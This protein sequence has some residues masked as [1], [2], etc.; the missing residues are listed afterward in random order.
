MNLDIL[1]FVLYASAVFV[2]LGITLVFS[3]FVGSKSRHGRAQDIPYESGIVPVG[4]AENMRLSVEFFLIAIFFVIFDLETIFIVAWAVAFN[5]VG[6]L[7]Y[8]ATAVFIFILLVA[9]FY[10]WR[11]GAL[12]WGVK[13]RHTDPQAYAKQESS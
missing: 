4:E 3:W 13:S 11:T 7:G 1:P 6:W 5:E 10:E 12:D 8:I 2:I 9:L